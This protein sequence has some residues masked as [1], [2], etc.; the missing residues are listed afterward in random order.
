MRK[1][2]LNS[3]NTILVINSQGDSNLHLNK[4][5]NS[6]HP[7]QQILALVPKVR[8]EKGNIASQ[9]LTILRLLN[10]TNPLSIFTIFRYL[11]KY[12]KVETVLFQLEL[13]KSSKLI[14]HIFLPVVL[15]G[16]KIAKKHVFFELNP[17]QAFQKPLLT[18]FYKAVARLADEMV[19]RTRG[20]IKYQTL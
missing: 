14:A 18:A 13:T 17:Q 20:R 11:W 1:R 3:Q 10:R 8:G 4:L 2:Y 7:Q 9:R 5:L 12:D 15:L 19:V 6:L 16:L